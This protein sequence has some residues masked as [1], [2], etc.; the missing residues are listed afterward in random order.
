MK[1]LLLRLIQQRRSKCISIFNDL[2]KTTKAEVIRPAIDTIA[3]TYVTAITDTLGYKTRRL[4][5]RTLDL[6]SYILVVFLSHL[7]F[8]SQSKTPRSHTHTTATLVLIRMER[9]LR[10]E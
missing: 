10:D 9:E 1:C 2:Q 6:P 3:S 8:T 4:L 5:S 7:T